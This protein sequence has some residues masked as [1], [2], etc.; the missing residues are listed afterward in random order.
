MDKNI[1]KERLEKQFAFCLEVDKEKKIERQT[2]ISDGSRQENDAEHAWH[3][4]LMTLILSEYANEEIDILK[5]ISMILIHDVVEID[6]G[7]TYAYD[8]EGKK[9]QKERE[10]KAADRIFAMLPEDQQ[11]KFRALWDEFEAA[12]TKEA[13]FARTM[14]NLQ[15]MMLNNATDGRRWQEKGVRL[16]QVLKRNERTPKGSKE[17]WDYAYENMLKPNVEKGKIVD[18]TIL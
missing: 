13:K 2:Y 10:L 12:E 8:E 5:T 4:A 9:T 7:D 3:M 14:D 18:D 16:S 6:A 1:S 11:V 17:L 15:P